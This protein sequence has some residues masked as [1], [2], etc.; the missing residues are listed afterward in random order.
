[1]KQVKFTTPVLSVLILLAA[2]PWQVGAQSAP[3]QGAD[4]GPALMPSQ[5]ARATFEDE[6]VK[7]FMSAVATNFGGKCDL[8]DYSNTQARLTQRGGGDFSSSFYDI[9][10]PCAG[11]NGLAAI[12]INAEFSPPLGTPLNLDLSLRYRK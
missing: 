9:A 2:F 8:P 12:Q 6:R 10:V 5:R 3:G 7:T 11:S 4:S 1:M